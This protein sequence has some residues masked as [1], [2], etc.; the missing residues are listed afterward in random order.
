MSMAATA[1]RLS[2]YRRPTT[3]FWLA[4][5]AAGRRGGGGRFHSLAPNGSRANRGGEWGPGMKVSGRGHCCCW[6]WRRQ[7]VVAAG[8]GGCIGRWYRLL[9]VIRWKEMAAALAKAAATGGGE[10][11]EHPAGAVGGTAC[12]IVPARKR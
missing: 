5:A 2:G 1:E 4:V 9:T 11:G 8:R 6:R 12:L 7:V 10:G 3:A